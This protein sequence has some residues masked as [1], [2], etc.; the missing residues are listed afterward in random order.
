MVTERN[1]RSRVAKLDTLVKRE[2]IYDFVQQDIKFI[3]KFEAA[4]DLAYNL[5]CT[6]FGAAIDVY[7][8]WF[9]GI[10]LGGIAGFET[11]RILKGEIV[12]SKAKAVLEFAL[13]RIQVANFVRDQ[14]KSKVVIRTRTGL[15]AVIGRCT[16]DPLWVANGG[17]IKTVPARVCFYSLHRRQTWNLLGSI[18]GSQIPNITKLGHTH[19]T[20]FLL[21]TRLA[22]QRARRA[23]LE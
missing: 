17:T 22:L 21:S 10:I 6:S 9:G 3:K 18:W 8:N 14:K 11:G 20:V 12:K 5:A 7:M 13:P 16:S 2:D 1:L 23:K 4:G 15:D 19:M